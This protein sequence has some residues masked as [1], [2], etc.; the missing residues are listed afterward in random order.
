MWGRGS[1]TLWCD[2]A[3][4]GGAPGGSL[5]RRWEEEPRERPGR[6]QREGRDEISPEDGKVGAWVAQVR[7]SEGGSVVGDNNLRMSP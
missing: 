3:L 6:V 5:D 4:N 1:E 7:G 2:D